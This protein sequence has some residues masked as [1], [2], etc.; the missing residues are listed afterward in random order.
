LIRSL[1]CVST[2]PIL[3]AKASE[4]I[5]T[6]WDETLEFKLDIS[7]L[8]TATL[9]VVG[10]PN[11]KGKKTE[12]SRFSITVRQIFNSKQTGGLRGLAAS[13][14]APPKVNCSFAINKVEL[15]R[16]DGHKLISDYATFD[17]A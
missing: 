17:V 8:S 15:P 14:S 10:V 11:S 1:K 9:I 7:K 16:F 13:Y 4:R 2:P 12:T 6:W 5:K 3:G